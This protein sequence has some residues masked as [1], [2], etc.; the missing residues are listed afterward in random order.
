MASYKR[1]G[2]DLPTLWG[3]Y[4]SPY[5]LGAPVQPLRS[6][7]IL[8]ELR[9]ERAKYLPTLGDVPEHQKPTVNSLL[10]WGGVVLAGALLLRG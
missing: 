7:M 2:P 5:I 10:I 6:P 3:T 4:T 1:L 9:G 8:N